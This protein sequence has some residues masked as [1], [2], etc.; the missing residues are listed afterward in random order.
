MRDAGYVGNIALASYE[1]LPP[2][3]LKY[4][5]IDKTPW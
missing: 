5:G 1:G 4:L 3:V 2:E